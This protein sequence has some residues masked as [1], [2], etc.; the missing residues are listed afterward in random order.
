MNYDVLSPRLRHVRELALSLMAKHGLNGWQFKFNRRKCAL[1]LC[2]APHLGR[3]GRIEL[4]RFYTEVNPDAAI[5]DTILHEIAH[6]LTGV[7]HGHDH[8]WRTTCLRI[9]ARPKRCGRAVMPPG[10]WK[11]VC[12]G[13]FTEHRR[14]RRPKRLDG[15]SCRRCGPTFGSLT[16]RRAA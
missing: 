11:A 8:V 13:C 14:H 5:V 1:G 12:R 4:S 15:W 6:A 2:V 16:W 7:E 3:P 9:G 10:G